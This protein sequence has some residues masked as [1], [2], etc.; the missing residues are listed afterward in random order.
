MIELNKVE[1]KVS[2][3]QKAVEQFLKI[4]ED[5]FELMLKSKL[6]TNKSDGGVHCF[7]DLDPYSIRGEKH[8]KK[9]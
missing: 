4:I 8:A 3:D 5:K 1:V 7:V 9:T 6:L 2:G